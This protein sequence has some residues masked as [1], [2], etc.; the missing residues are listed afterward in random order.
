MQFPSLR[1]GRSDRQANWHAALNPFTAL[2]ARTRTGLAA[3]VVVVALFLLAASLN[4]LVFKPGESFV[5]PESAGAASDAPI[6]EF[7]PILFDVFLVL[8]GIAFLV[9][10]VIAVRSPKDRRLVLRNVGQLLLVAAIGLLVSSL[11]KPEEEIELQTTPQAPAPNPVSEPLEVLGNSGTP[12]PVTFV[13]PVVPGW[14]RYAVTLAVI[15]LA[16]AFGYW[17]WWLSHTPKEQLHEITRLALDDLFA[18]RNWEDVVIQCY[19]DM[20]SAISRKRGVGRHHAMT[21]REFAVRLEQVG[22]PVSAVGRLTRLFEEA[23]YGSGQST[24]DQVQ[25]ATNCLAEIMR[26]VEGEVH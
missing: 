1:H 26:A 19:A 4:N 2:P 21:P 6:I 11:Y 22:L 5:L 8:L 18:G 9:S 12:V 15:G 23:R 14:A 10:L 20:S 3:A 25:E 16:G 17:I 24:S 13:P 7:P